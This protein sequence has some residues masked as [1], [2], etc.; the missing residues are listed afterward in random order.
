MNVCFDGVR[1]LV[2]DDQADI[3]YVNTTTSEIRG[4][5]NI[6]VPGAQRLQSGFSLFLVLAR[7]QGRRAPLQKRPG[8]LMR[9]S[10]DSS[11]RTPARWRSFATM[12]AVF[13]WLTNTMIGGVYWLL[14][15][16][17]SI[18]CLRGSRQHLDSSATM[19]LARTS[20]SR[21]H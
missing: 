8:E 19:G 5:K 15:R 1:H 18:R 12:S 21:R 14:L 3:L 13:F 16:I 17:S 11:L 2:V 20:S 10:S 4:N 7:V 6:R 9:G